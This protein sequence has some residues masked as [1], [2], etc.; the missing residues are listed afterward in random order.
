MCLKKDTHVQCTG[1][2]V[3]LNPQNTVVHEQ[4]DFHN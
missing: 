4:Y 2:N 1:N 3:P